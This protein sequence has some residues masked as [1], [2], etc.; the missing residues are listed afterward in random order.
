M[1]Q[2]TFINQSPGGGFGHWDILQDGLVVGV[3]L[4]TRGGP[5]YV[6]LLQYGKKQFCARFKYARKTACAKDFIKFALKRFDVDMILAGCAAMSPMGWAES[7]G[8]V[9]LNIRLAEKRRQK[10]WGATEGAAA[11]AVAVAQMRR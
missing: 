1:H 5:T 2:V 3:I 4:S 7:H 9:H 8:Y 6:E 11:E 10:F